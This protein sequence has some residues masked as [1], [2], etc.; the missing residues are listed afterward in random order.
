MKWKIRKGVE[1]DLE[2]VLNM[3]KELAIFEGAPEEVSNT[4]EMMQSQRDLFDF[5]IAEIN[6]HYVGFALYHYTY[7][8]WKG[9]SLYLEDLFVRA[10]HRGKG[11]G[12][13][14]LNLVFNVAYNNNCQ[15]LRWQ[16]L[17][18]N[19]SAIAFYKKRGATISSEWLNCDFDRNEIEKIYRNI[20]PSLNLER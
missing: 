3:V 7:S 6:N 8:T 14:L 11:I 18:W 20:N 2:H 19:Q 12:S 17:D 5:H 15:R 10:S 13:A 1:T 4:L 16:V 9:K